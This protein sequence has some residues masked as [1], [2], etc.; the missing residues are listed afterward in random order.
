MQDIFVFKNG[1]NKGKDYFGKGT[2]IVNFADV[3]HKNVL[4]ATSIQGLVMVNEKEIVNFQIKKGDVFFTR[5]SETIHDIGMSAV[6][7]EDI[8][9]GVFSG[10]VLRARP[11]NNDLSNPF[12]AYCF[13]TPSVRKEIVTKSSFTTRA[14][15]SGTLLNKVTLIYPGSKSEQEKIGEFL[16]AIDEK[17]SILQQKIE[18]LHNYKK[19]VMQLIF[20]QKIR[21]KH[22]QGEPFSEWHE[23]TVQ[24]VFNESNN[25]TKTTDEFAILSSTQSG[26]YLQSDY[27][28][29]QTASLD[30][31]G[32]KIIN[33][34][35]F[36]YRA[37][38]DTGRFTFNLQNLVDTGIVSPA[39]PVFQIKS[40]HVS[41]FFYYYLNNS[42][43]IKKQILKLKEGGT[44][45]ALSYTKFSKLHM[46]VPEN[47]EQQKIA[48]FLSSLDEK[49][50][51]EQAKL[52]QAKLFK[53]ALL[54]R[55][56]V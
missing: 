50:I 42:S 19:G 56:F 15:T 51:L 54:Q 23:E 35:E 14:L 32:Y 9:D 18:R 5:T 40:N 12:K 7:T 49:I 24:D 21:F 2:P 30:N 44:R 53:K 25:K 22:D 38:S 28:N 52:E 27:F 6:Q 4:T 3:Y 29:K 43:L 17:L 31:S 46:V 37:M 36:T 55:M 48:D 13:S 1:L 45:L 41:H 26:I 34:G 10:F 8:K 47:E 33:R 16:F 39:Y 20:N 11:M